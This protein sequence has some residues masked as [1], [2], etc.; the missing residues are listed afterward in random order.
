VNWLFSKE[1]FAAL[2]SGTS[3]LFQQKKASM[4]IQLGRNEPCWC[5]SGKK[6]KH[7]HRKQDQQAAAAPPPV[8][9]PAAMESTASDFTRPAPYVPPLPPERS[10]ADLALE[11]E[12]D[13]FRQADVD[14][15][16][17][18]FLEKLDNRSLEAEDSFEMILA[19][20][21]ESDVKHNAEA[22]VR[23]AALLDR[24]RRELPE[25]YQQDQH[26]YLEDLIEDAIADQHWAALPDLFNELAAL[27]PGKIDEFFRVV[28]AALYHGQ[29]APVLAALQAAWS[30]VAD[31]PAI[32]SYGID[33]YGSLIMQLLLYEYVERAAA[34]DADSTFM[35]SL[36]AYG[37]PITVWFERALHH[38]TAPAPTAWQAADFGE[39][40][41]AEQWAINVEGLW[42]DFMAD[43]R[44]QA[45]VPYSKSH[46]A[47]KELLHALHQQFAQP[48]TP[49]KRAKGKTRRKVA[50][51]VPPVS[52]LI[53]R[54]KTLDHELG[55]QFSIFGSR[56]YHAGAPLELLPAYLHFIARLGLIHPSELDE[57]LAELRPL[58]A[59]IG[60]TLTSYGGDVHLAQAVEAAWSETNL[61][62]LR[63]DPALDAA[64]AQPI[65]ITPPIETAVPQTFTVKV[66]YRGEPD[67]WFILELRADQTLD[68]LHEAILDAADFDSDHLYSF[69]L[70]GRA[71]DEDTE[72]A[73]QK[74][75]YSSHTR[76]SN[77]RVRL[78]QRWLYLFDYGDQHEFDVQL[79]AT[80]PDQ[81]RGAYPRLIE[82]H[83]QLPPQY[84]GEEDEEWTDEDLDS[85]LA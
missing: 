43:Q 41:D 84:P 12:W 37:T 57:A 11:V 63:N 21:D 24:L 49:G 3:L 58:T 73:P 70:S 82:Q 27:L 26:F 45:A 55:Q 83:G 52:P 25:V 76:L 78:K 32:T 53:P 36:S 16:V 29:A 51:A 60:Q 50:P 61:D 71:W 48:A 69:Y 30:A 66:T 34:R 72:Y 31:T 33:E 14:G 54:F 28:Y 6:Y 35:V 64:R 77:L 39:A 10:A 79:I 59:N 17:A 5:G 85:D 7:C 80:S 18:M 15:K 42:F 56:P 8:A 44:R 40:V 4:P 67:A 68:H 74:A 75:R 65:V 23:C 9:A 38:L 20:R 19:I 81:P 22:R 47:R 1:Q 2:T 62:A 13:H 46:L